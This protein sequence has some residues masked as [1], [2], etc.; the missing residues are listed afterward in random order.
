M[1][2]AKNLETIADVAEE[3]K[4][5]KAKKVE[6]STALDSP[7]W[8]EMV[9]VRIPKEAKGEENFRTFSVN[10]REYTIMKGVKV[11]VPAPIADLIENI[12]QAEE[13]ADAYAST[14][15]SI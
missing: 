1:A 6:P 14:L 5:T 7:Y 12:Y 3:K 2:T 11:S 4:G 13:E 15:K 8:N 9:E 10:G